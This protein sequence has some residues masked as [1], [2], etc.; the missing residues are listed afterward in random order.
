[1]TSFHRKTVSKSK[2]W[3][4][5]YS[6]VAYIIC[7]GYITCG[8]GF[9][10]LHMPGVPIYI[11]EVL[12]LLSLVY[13]VPTLNKY[14]FTI[15]QTR[16]TFVLCGFGLLFLNDLLFR[17]QNTF[18]SI[19]DSA[20]FYY[21]LFVLLYSGKQ[22]APF[23]KKII[24]VLT[25]YHY[26]IGLSLLLHVVISPF[27]TSFLIIGDDSRG[28]FSMPGCL[29]PPLASL[30]IV[31]LIEQ[32][33][34]HQSNKLGFVS[35]VISALAI[36][37][38][39]SRGGILGAVTALWYYVF[40]LSKSKVRLMSFL[41]KLMILISII[42]LLI[43]PLLNPI[44]EYLFSSVE[45]RDTDLISTD[46]IISKFQNLVSSQGENYKGATGEGRLLWWKAIINYN[47]KSN[48]TLL[49]GQGF[50]FNLGEPI[51][52][53]KEGTRGAH[54]SFVNI[55][56]WSGLVGTSLYLMAFG[57]IFIK[58]IYFRK[59]QNKQDQTS[60]MACNTGL[61]FLVSTL[62]ASLFDNSL[63]SPVTAIPLFIFLG[64]ALSVL[65]QSSDNIR[66]LR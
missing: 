54:N 49:I 18:E 42:F 6:F 13:F 10:G 62:V 61:V 53:G 8:R 7:F 17:N 38:C 41:G 21:I 45:Y 28:F 39:Q 12:L 50:G 35:I 37:L 63:S 36:L 40:F 5:F 59:K 32:R 27:L 51:D 23:F 31:V 46:I 30:L 3:I 58:C 11:G 33:Y 1:M 57:S 4:W 29:V 2:R 22:G 60:I 15:F 9:A 52:Y 26:I 48:K 65:D 64:S 47:M 43:I 14:G 56:G 20:T 24:D 16:I 34:S 55:F 25:K 44:Q 66:C 19:R